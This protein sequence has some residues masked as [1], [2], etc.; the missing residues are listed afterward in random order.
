M[1]LDDHAQA[2][3]LAAKVEATRRAIDHLFQEHEAAALAFSGGA[4]SVT[5]LHLCRPCGAG[6]RT[7]MRG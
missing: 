6:I 4:D 1:P 7:C 3:A 5:L 2:D